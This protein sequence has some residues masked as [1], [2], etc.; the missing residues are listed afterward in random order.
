MSRDRADGTGDRR[1][2]SCGDRSG[3]AT[4]CSL[5]KRDFR[6]WSVQGIASDQFD[7]KRWSFLFCFVF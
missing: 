7:A 5:C 6:S 3:N 2:G 1:G 4:I